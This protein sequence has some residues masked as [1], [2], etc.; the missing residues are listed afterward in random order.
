MWMA[1]W[2]PKKIK[3]KKR[4]NKKSDPSQG[5]AVRRSTR[6]NEIAMRL[7]DSYNLGRDNNARI[8]SL[9]RD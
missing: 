8:R 9:R 4:K 1:E 2:V 6:L 3:E 5:S 7:V